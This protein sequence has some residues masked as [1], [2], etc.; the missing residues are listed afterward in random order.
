MNRAPMI[1]L[2]C[3]TLAAAS[4]F[5][6]PLPAQTAPAARVSIDA[7]GAVGD[8]TT[9]NTQAIQAAIDALA[10]KGGGTIVIPKG[11]FLTGALFLKPGIHLELLEGAI[12]KGSK[13][14][15][16]YPVLDNIRFEGHFQRRIAA[17]LNVERSD[18]FRLTGAGTIHGNGEHYWDT[19][20]PNGRPRLCVI[21]DSRDIVVSGIRFYNSPQWNLHLYNCQDVV[22]E[23]CR[24]EI[25]DRGKG[26]ST[27]GVDIDSSQN[28]LVRNCFFSVNDDC[29]CLKGN[30]YDGLNQEPK[31]PPVRNVRVE[32]CTFVRGHGALTLGTE[33]QGIYDVE[34]TDSMVS[35][36]MPMLRIKL[37][38]D[39]PNQDYQNIRV[40]NVRLE[41]GRPEVIR[42]SP[43]HGTKVAPLVA[44]ISKV[45]D[46]LV[47]NITGEAQDFGTLSGGRTAT[48]SNVTLRNINVTVTRNAE[49]N[50][51]GVTGVTLKNVS[52]EKVASPT[53]KP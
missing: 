51:A 33:A 19:P 41:R 3:L 12:L 15:D 30:R 9:M 39:T 17:L 45:S 42:V 4:A 21:R 40:R 34:M 5:S 47:E 53:T 49:L 26:P 8:G 46:I 52:V 29:V 32:N 35:G 10:A 28:V 14:F 7:H 25:D 23:N 31:S 11:E 2:A 44:P 37:R 48:V 6:T 20:S 22:V 24:F 13:N 18:G 27:D 36:N 16:D 50:T 43:T 38:P 1:R